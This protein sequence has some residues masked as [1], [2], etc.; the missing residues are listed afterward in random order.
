MIYLNVLYEIRQA[1]IYFQRTGE[2]VKLQGL[3]TFTPEIGL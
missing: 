1:M 3:G 2:A